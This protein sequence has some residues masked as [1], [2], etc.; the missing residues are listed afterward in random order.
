MKGI[1]HTE[2]YID[3]IYCTGK[4]PEEHIIILSEI[5]Q[6]IEKVGLNLNDNHKNYIVTQ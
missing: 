6:R 1:P 4:T 2:I 5:F 3:N